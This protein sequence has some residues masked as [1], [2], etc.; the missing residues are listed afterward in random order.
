[1]DANGVF[2]V[3]DYGPQALWL[4]VNDDPAEPYRSA[5]RDLGGQ[6]ASDTA[7]RSE[8]AEWAGDSTEAYHTPGVNLAEQKG[9]VESRR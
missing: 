4:M 9:S 8:R 1:M 6:K 5:F 3:A 2:S 7:N